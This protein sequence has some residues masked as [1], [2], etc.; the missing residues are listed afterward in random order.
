MF[1]ASLASPTR[2][3]HARYDSISAQK[4]HAK[5]WTVLQSMDKKIFDFLWNWQVQ[6]LDFILVRSVVVVVLFFSFLF[7]FLGGGGGGGGGS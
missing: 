2:N 7:F 6:L 3:F 4:T 5:I 1:L